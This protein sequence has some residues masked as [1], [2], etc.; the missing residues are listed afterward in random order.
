MNMQE[1]LNK[2]GL[3]YIQAGR[4]TVRQL[5]TKMCEEAGIPPESKFVDID[6]F[7]GSKYLPFYNQ[8]LKQLW[9]AERQ[10]RDGGYVGL[11]IGRR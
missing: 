3:D 1:R 6:C 5:W 4:A 10:Y 9:E 8:A 7:T 11:Q 2:Q